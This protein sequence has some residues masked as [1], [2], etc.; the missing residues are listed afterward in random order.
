MQFLWATLAFLLHLI[1]GTAAVQ[2][3]S[4]AAEQKVLGWVL[5]GTLSVVLPLYL[6]SLTSTGSWVAGV[7]VGGGVSLAIA[8]AR[9]LA[10]LSP[11]LAIALLVAIISAVV[12]LSCLVRNVTLLSRSG[13]DG[14][15]PPP[16]GGGAYRGASAPVSGAGHSVAASR[17]AA[18]SGGGGG[19]G[20][21]RRGPSATASHAAAVAELFKAESPPL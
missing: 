19:G 18:S 13:G 14:E 3:L 2:L 9:V 8:T 20:S 12:G 17:T 21:S 11:A 10:L 16:T 4:G 7:V 15:L 1:V 5:Y 6:R